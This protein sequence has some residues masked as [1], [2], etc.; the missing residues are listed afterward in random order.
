MALFTHLESGLYVISELVDFTV[1]MLYHHSS[2][3]KGLQVSS[4]DEEK[5]E[6]EGQ[7]YFEKSLNYVYYGGQGE[8][9]QM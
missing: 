6:S 1:A 2:L 4:L 3:L 5:R 9:G 7:A 8:K